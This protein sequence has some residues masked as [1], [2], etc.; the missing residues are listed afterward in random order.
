M[1][2]DPLRDELGLEI[3]RLVAI[4]PSPELRAQVGARIA[5][6]QRRAWWVPRWPMI[7]IGVAA[8]AVAAIIVMSRVDV[9]Q[10]LPASASP[11]QAS[12]A[13]PPATAPP[14][15]IPPRTASRPVV[16]ARAAKHR[17]MHQ[18]IS[19]PA[20]VTVIPLEPLT[21]IAIAPV[22]IEPLSPLPPLSG[23]RQ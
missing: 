5:G 13:P 20:R 18:P 23:E 10:P 16:V 9:V 12:V 4:A 14:S 22:A 1:P 3:E 2:A 11:Q 17:V 7:G 8:A 21:E 15:E 19:A 6:Q